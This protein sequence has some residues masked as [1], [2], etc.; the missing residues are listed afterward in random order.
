MAQ[1]VTD[2][3]GPPR[4]QTYNPNGVDVREIDHANI[5]ICSWSMVSDNDW[6]TIVGGDFW[7]YGMNKTYDVVEI[8]DGTIEVDHKVG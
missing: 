6:R 2:S 7:L 4:Q 3:G 8:L 5:W 1:L